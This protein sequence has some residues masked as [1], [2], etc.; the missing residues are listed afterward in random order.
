M[1]RLRGHNCGPSCCMQKQTV[2]WLSAACI[3]IV[4]DKFMHIRR[5]SKACFDNRSTPAS[6]TNGSD[7]PVLA[8]Y[9]SSSTMNSLK[10]GVLGLSDAEQ[11]LLGT[12]MRLHRV[13]PSFIWS[14]T[15]EPPFDALLVD[16]DVSPRSYV[17]QV[18]QRTM[19]KRLGRR[20]ASKPGEMPRPIRSDL[21]VEWLTSI[22]AIQWRKAQFATPSITSEV[23]ACASDDVAPIKALSKK[24]EPRQYDAGKA[25]SMSYDNMLFK[26]KRWPPAS[27]LARDAAR[28]RVATLLSRKA[29]SLSDLKTLARIPDVAF[30]PFLRELDLQGYLVTIEHGAPVPLTS[31][32]PGTRTKPGIASGLIHSLRRRL[33]IG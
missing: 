1:K 31:K 18:D 27:A 23:Q 6:Q 26:L 2:D 19:V 20:G 30:F 32:S 5:C 29:L 24:D 9:S 16:A 15:T 17:E 10:L 21:L 3:T 22:E 13:D 14:L 8:G 33:G 7:A 4:D 11:T 12:L 25:K 28:I